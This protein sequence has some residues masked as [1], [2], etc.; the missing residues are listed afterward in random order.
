[1]SKRYLRTSYLVKGI[2]AKLF[3]EKAE[4]FLKRMKLFLEIII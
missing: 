2:N 4:I 1:M 3:K